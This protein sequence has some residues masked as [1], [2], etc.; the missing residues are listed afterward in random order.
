MKQIEEAE[1]ARANAQRLTVLAQPHRRGDSSQMAE[2]A[3]GRFIINNKLR[4][5]CFDAGEQWATV[6]RKWLVAM[7]CRIPGG[8]GGSGADI[9]MELVHAWRDQCLE[10]EVAMQRAGGKD[11]LC[12]VVWMAFHHYDFAPGADP[13][14]AIRALMALAVQQGKLP[15][16]VMS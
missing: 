10:G 13:R 16:T 2:S 12:S 7:G 3:L 5:E 6:K 1:L 14:L 9:P 4:S 11:G 15:A 8:P